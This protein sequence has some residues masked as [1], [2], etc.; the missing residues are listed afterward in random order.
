MISSEPVENISLPD[1][2]L[3]I[4]P[5]G[6]KKTILSGHIFQDCKSANIGC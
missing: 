1:S 6:E 3:V 5:K 4:S 2:D